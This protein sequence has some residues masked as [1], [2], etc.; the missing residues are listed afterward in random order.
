VMARRKEPVAGMSGP[1]NTMGPVTWPPLDARV[2]KPPKAEGQ[3]S[4]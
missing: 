4:T 3:S 2:A 1:V